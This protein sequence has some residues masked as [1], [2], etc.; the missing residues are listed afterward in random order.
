MARG[1]IRELG[2]P[3]PVTS[4]TFTLMNLYETSKGPLHHFDW[5]RIEDPEEL[6]LAGLDEFIG[7]DSITLIEW[8]ERA[9]DL[10]P[11]THLLL[12][13]RVAGEHERELDFQSNGAFRP[14]DMNALKGGRP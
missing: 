2:F 11:E 5:Y 4:P 9:R 12:T 6:V 14:L 7:G 3:G 13:I 10:V 8:S 1:I